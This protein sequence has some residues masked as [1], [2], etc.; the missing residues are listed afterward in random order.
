MTGSSFNSANRAQGLRGSFLSR[1]FFAPASDDPSRWQPIQRMLQ[2]AQPRHWPLDVM[3]S[4]LPR[5]AFKGAESIVGNVLQKARFWE[6][7][8]SDQLNPRQ[9]KVLNR[10]L[11]GFEGNL[12]SSK[13]ATLTNSSQDTAGA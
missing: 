9:R 5:K 11:D 8:P 7:F 13:W 3:V 2:Q 4:R 1:L 12:T 6:A 10:L